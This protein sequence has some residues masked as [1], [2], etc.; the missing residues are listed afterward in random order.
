MNTLI[1]LYDELHELEELNSKL[2][3]KYQSIEF[4]SNISEMIDISEQ[5]L[6]ITFNNFKFFKEH[7][8]ETNKELAFMNIE[9]LIKR[10][11]ELK[12]LL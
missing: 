5:I 1:K 9:Y 11:N 10:I 3:V 8:S 7:N 6:I 12:S 4:K 2:N